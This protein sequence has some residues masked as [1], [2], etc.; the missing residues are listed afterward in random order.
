[1]WKKNKRY[2]GNNIP[3]SDDFVMVNIKKYKA[4]I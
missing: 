3:I 2:L 1:M 4:E